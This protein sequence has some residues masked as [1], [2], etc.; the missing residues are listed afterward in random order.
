MI[1]GGGRIAAVPVEHL[2]A[3]SIPLERLKVDYWRNREL[4]FDIGGDELAEFFTVIELLL[5]RSS[6]ALVRRE[7]K[8]GRRHGLFAPTERGAQ[9][10]KVIHDAGGQRSEFLLAPLDQERRA[11]FLATFD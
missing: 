6:A 5:F 9:L 2:R 1:P 11:R 8:P 10:H 4:T 3:C 7:G